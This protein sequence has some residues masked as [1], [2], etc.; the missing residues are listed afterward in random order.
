MSARVVVM[1]TRTGHVERVRRG[2]A[3]RVALV[4]AENERV[5]SFECR[6]QWQGVSSERKTVDWSWKAVIEVTELEDDA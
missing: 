1:Q 2:T 5:V 3:P 6:E 4:L